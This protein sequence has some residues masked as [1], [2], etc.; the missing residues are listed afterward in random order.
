[1][2]PPGQPGGGVGETKLFVGGGGWG[3]GGD[4]KTPPRKRPIK[5]NG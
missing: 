4:D 1:M 2:E 5:E 3:G